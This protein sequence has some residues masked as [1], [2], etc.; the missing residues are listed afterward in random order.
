MARLPLFDGAR[1]GRGLL[2]P[3]LV[4][5]ARRAR[6]DLPSAAGLLGVRDG[7]GA[8]ARLA[9]ELREVPAAPRGAI[10]S[11]TRSLPVHPRGR[12]SWT[13]AH[14]ARAAA[15]GR[16]GPPDGVR[17]LLRRWKATQAE[18]ESGPQIGRASW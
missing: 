17:P 5:Y 16:A 3:G 12:R 1:A 8:R 15:R 14:A 4:G 11:V 7:P 18:G 9:P 2:P 6:A 13:R 10:R